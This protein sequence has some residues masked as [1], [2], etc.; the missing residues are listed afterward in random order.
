MHKKVKDEAGNTTKKYSVN[1]E[2]QSIGIEDDDKV[3]AGAQLAMAT[4]APGG[5][6]A[7][8]LPQGFFF[9]A[10][11][12]CMELRKKIAEDYKIW[13]V[14]DIASGSFI[15]TGTKSFMLVFQKGV[16]PTQS[17]KFI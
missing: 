6:C 7:I 8:V 5:V 12:K 1:Q 13:Y 9:G 10:S 4:L 11:K 14:V 16:G 17:V 3:S 2:I 15:N